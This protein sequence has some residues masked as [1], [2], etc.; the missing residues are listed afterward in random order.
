MIG[1]ICF[2]VSIAQVG[3]RRHVQWTTKT[4][5]SGKI[6]RYI[7]QQLE[8]GDFFGLVS[9]HGRLV[10]GCGL[11]PTFLHLFLASRGTMGDDEESFML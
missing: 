5:S 11:W 2:F 10:K 6:A 4:K 1:C 8:V 7:L 9:S 3:H